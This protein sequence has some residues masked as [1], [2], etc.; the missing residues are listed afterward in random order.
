[1]NIE[2]GAFSVDVRVSPGAN[3]STIEEAVANALGAAVQELTDVL[4]CPDCFH[5]WDRHLPDPHNDGAGGC[6]D[7][8]CRCTEPR[9]AIT[10]AERIAAIRAQ[11]GTT[12]LVSTA[13]DKANGEVGGV[14]WQ[15]V[16]DMANHAPKGGTIVE[17]YITAEGEPGV[18]CVTF[19]GRKGNLLTTVARLL[20]SECISIEPA[21][22]FRCYRT[23]RQLFGVIGQRIDA[24]GPPLNDV[25]SR[26]AHW[27]WSLLAATS[28]DPS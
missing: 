26:Y 1:M 6:A 5:P 13:Q 9:Q 7:P 22:R 20:A 2:P 17:R 11:L 27:A 15:R 28:A 24:S 14:A 18:V 4:T 12:P 25:E 19:L 21:D 16:A 10:P 3:T 8:K 23:A